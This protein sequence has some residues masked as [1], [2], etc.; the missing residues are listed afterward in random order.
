MKKITLF[1]LSITISLH[2]LAQTAE[3]KTESK[4]RIDLICELYNHDLNDSLISQAPKDMAFHKSTEQW[5]HYYETWMHL[6]NTYTFMGK[7]NTALREVKLL[8]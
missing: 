6:V 8:L 1:I 2:S 4:K 5:E 7:V 3:E